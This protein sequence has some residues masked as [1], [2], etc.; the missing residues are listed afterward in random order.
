MEGLL[1]LRKAVFVAVMM[2]TPAM[3]TDFSVP[4]L[5]VDGSPFPVCT[6]QSPDG[7]SCAH[8]LKTVGELIA[9]AVDADTQAPAHPAA[10]GPQQTAQQPLGYQERI[11]RADLAAKVSKRSSVQLISEEQTIAKEAVAKLTVP[12]AVVAQA[13]RLIDA[14]LDF[15]TTVKEYDLSSK[16]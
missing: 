11:K 4:I 3:A 7:K 8:E 12:N 15:V 5:G 14:E 2:A 10:F 1:M 9:F 13:V 6:R 16:K